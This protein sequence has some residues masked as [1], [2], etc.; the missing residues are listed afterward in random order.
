M[1][2]YI[3]FDHDGVLVDTE[4]WYYKA[5][6]RAL[7]DIGLVAVSVG[8]AEEGA[9]EGY[10]SERGLA[11]QSDMFGRCSLEKALADVGRVPT[12]KL[13][14]PHFLALPDVLGDTDLLALVPEPLACSLCARF[15]L[16]QRPLPY[17]A[18][19]T[20]LQM[21]WHCRNTPEPG[22]GWLRDQLQQVLW[23]AWGIERVK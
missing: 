8:G 13:T 16:Q 1:K 9:V 23:E 4:F 6:E 17:S 10:I 20:N 21:V 11:R 15:S 5:G 18:P 3:L 19:P 14:L 22:H 2:K 12:F 7:A